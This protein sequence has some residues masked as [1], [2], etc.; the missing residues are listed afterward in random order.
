MKREGKS[1]TEIGY[2]LGLNRQTVSKYWNEYQ[3]LSKRLENATDKQEIAEIQERM[4]GGP[5]YKTGHR[6]PT[7]K[8]KKFY[9][10]LNYILAGEAEK[11]KEYKHLHRLQL[12]KQL[13]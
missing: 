10:D 13:N 2:V 4:I 7:K 6:N 1:F 8:T 9:N 11:D 12:L 5:Q 3:E